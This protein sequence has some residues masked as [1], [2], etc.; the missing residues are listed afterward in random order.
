MTIAN[1]QHADFQRSQGVVGSDEGQG[2]R[3]R[4][5]LG[6]FGALLL[7]S[8]ALLAPSPVTAQYVSD[9]ALH[10]SDESTPIGES[11]RKKLTFGVGVGS[12]YST[13]G[14]NI[15]FHDSKSLTVL[16][17]GCNGM[18][19][20]RGCNDSVTLGYYRTDLFGWDSGRHA[21]GLWGGRVGSS[22]YRGQD[23]LNSIAP[24]DV[25][26]NLDFGPVWGFGVGYL[27][28]HRGIGERGPVFGLGYQFE[29]GQNRRSDGTLQLSLGFQF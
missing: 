25:T 14:A 17:I 19:S 15:G 18:S 27:Y 10:A 13:A 6:W 23:S 29:K 7:F 20:F 3:A 8:S 11:D 2:P 16:S 22:S 28:F 12:L 26:N 5:L 4:S 9:A 24:S 1:V 21:L